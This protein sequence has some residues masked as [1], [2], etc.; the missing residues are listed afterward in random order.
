M[1]KMNI[2]KQVQEQFGKNAAHYVTSEIHAK[3]QDLQTLLMLS[4]A[5]KTD[6]VLDIATG[7]GHVAN[8]FAPLVEKVVA[9]DL[10]ENMLQ[11]AKEFIEGNGYYNIEFIQGDAEQLPFADECFD[12]VTCR[13]A[14]HHF[15][16]VSVFIAESYRVLKKGGTFLLI[17]NVAPED[18][19]LD[20]FYNTVEKTRDPS[21]NRALK[22]TQWI[23]ELEK[24]GFTVEQLLT[25]AKT[26]SFESWFARMGLPANVKQSLERYMLSA[27][28][29]AKQHFHITVQDERIISFQGQSV[30]ITCKKHR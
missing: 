21:H 18:D 10:T 8:G 7:G 13:I 23:N 2:K 12:I 5:K 30:L 20:T 6:V 14:P 9:L 11:K 26:F 15:P 17:D 28:L 19:A 24:A 16:D 29:S 1:V 27:S 4:G 25:F 22:K 3:G